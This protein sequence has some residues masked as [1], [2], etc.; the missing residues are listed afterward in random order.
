MF[1]WIYRVFSNAAGVIDNTVRNW[2]HDLVNGLYSF[3][4]AV[5]GLVGTAWRS[6]DRYILSFYHQLTA[7]LQSIYRVLYH[8]YKVLLPAMIREYRALVASALAFARQVLSYAVKAFNTAITYALNL[9][10]DA[11][12]WVITDIWDPIWKILTQAWDWV[13]G[14]GETL[15][16]YLTHPADL[17]DLLWDALLA[18]IEAEAWTAGELLGKFFLSLIVHNLQRIATLIEDILDAVF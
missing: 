6:A 8:A 11:R 18:K 4:H 13:T 14:K 5:F 15:W 3:L 10:N 1:S 7:V 16:H 2:V 17:V 12:R 9:V